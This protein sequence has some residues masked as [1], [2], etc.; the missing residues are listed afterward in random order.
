MFA[1]TDDVDHGFVGAPLLNGGRYRAQRLASGLYG[2]GPCH[3]LGGQVN[4]PDTRKPGILLAN[5]Q[6]G[7]VK[8]Q[9]L[10]PE[11]GE[12]WVSYPLS[13]VVRGWPYV[14]NYT[15]MAAY[16]AHMAKLPMEPSFGQPEIGFSRLDDNWLARYTTGPQGVFDP[17]IALKVDSGI[18]WCAGKPSPQK[19]RFDNDSALAQAYGANWATDYPALVAASTTD[20]ILTRS[21][22][23]GTYVTISSDAC[24]ENWWRCVQTVVARLG[25][26]SDTAWLILGFITRIGELVYYEL[27]EYYPS[28][29]PSSYTLTVPRFATHPTSS[30][31]PATL[32]VAKEA[33]GNLTFSVDNSGASSSTIKEMS[34]NYNLSQINSGPSSPYTMYYY[35]DPKGPVAQLSLI[36]Y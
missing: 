4:H 14:H 6:Y 28:G 22:F 30:Q 18:G 17:E 7:V 34:G 33:G 2:V 15:S 31:W 29:P 36:S 13:V 26:S 11:W 24:E 8:C 20:C 35:Q 21:V 32:D 23:D 12:I 27:P 25:E 19:W 9:W 3:L 5:G 1:T 10:E 16:G